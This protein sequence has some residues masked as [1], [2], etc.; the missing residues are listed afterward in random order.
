VCRSKLVETSINFGKINS[1]TKL[2]LVGISTGKKKKSEFSSAS[3]RTLSFS[4]PGTNI[5]NSCQKPTNAQIYYQHHFINAMSL[6]HVLAF[7]G[8]RYISKARSTK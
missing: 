6:Q 2:H 4:C 1:I 5:E 3:G 8:L 7:K